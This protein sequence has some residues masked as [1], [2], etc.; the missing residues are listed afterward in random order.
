MELDIKNNNF[1]YFKWQMSTP[2]IEVKSFFDNEKADMTAGGRNG[3]ADADIAE[4]GSLLVTKYQ[5]AI[6]KEVKALGEDGKERL[7]KYDQLCECVI[8]LNKNFIAYAGNNDAWKEAMLDIMK[9]LRTEPQAIVVRVEKLQN[10]MSNMAFIRNMT[11]DKINSP[12]VK[13]AS[14]NGRIECV[15]DIGTI[16]QYDSIITVVKGVMNTSLG[17]RSIRIS[18]DGKVQISKKKGETVLHDS[19]TWAFSLIK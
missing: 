6:T 14:F 3:F 16:A 5:A 19:I 4:D 17:V 11:L 8:A 1:K 7:E 18:S 9:R 10:I 12:N 13:H 2:L 15:S